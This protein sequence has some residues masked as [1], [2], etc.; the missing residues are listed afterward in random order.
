[1]KD[2]AE[3]MWLSDG[4]LYAQLRQRVRAGDVA[5]QPHADAL[6]R[7]AAAVCGSPAP[8]VTDKRFTL[9]SP[10]REPH[11]YVSI[12]TYFWP[13][14]ESPDGLPYVVRDGRLSPDLHLYDR[15]RWDTAVD[16][17]VT[18]L[19]A[20]YFLDEPRYAAEAARRI[21]RWFLDPA[22]RMNPHLAYAQMVPGR[23]TGRP[24]GIVDFALGLPTLVDHMSLFEPDGSAAWTAADRAALAAWCAEFLT[25]LETHPFGRQEEAS[26][27][28]HGTFYDRLVVSL[29]L[30][31]ARPER[32][33]AQLAKTRERIVTQIE[34]DGKM[35]HELRRTCSFGYT[36]MN[37]RG[38]VDLAWLGRGLGVEFWDWSGPD[39]Q[40]I[41]AAMD[42]FLGYAGTATAWPWEQIEPIDWRMV[43][44]VL[45]KANVL[46]GGAYSC[47][48]IAHRLPPGFVPEFFVLNEP[49]HPFR[50]G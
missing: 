27:N 3:G 41:R 8:A 22:S 32:A 17:M 48:M 23:E 29:A 12:G 1:M 26:A 43:C 6:R 46:S 7:H 37:L 14:P 39:G 16:G 28:N 5:I 19:R 24:Y 10:S 4:E 11:D 50:N 33:A 15:P 13:N 40:S 38:L 47:A 30:F 34:P 25:W 31:L 35:P 45:H 44:P 49:L 18:T 9:H 21:R 42:W 20:A 36:L 2:R